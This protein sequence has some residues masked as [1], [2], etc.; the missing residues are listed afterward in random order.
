MLR[1]LT[2]NFTLNC[3]PENAYKRKLS[4][5][6]LHVRLASERKMFIIGTTSFVSPLA[7]HAT[8]NLSALIFFFA[9]GE[10]ETMMRG[11][12][13]VLSKQ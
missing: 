1:L 6:R 10:M 3:K 8:P 2:N 5:L 11:N 7:F 12:V 13:G 4:F 9:C